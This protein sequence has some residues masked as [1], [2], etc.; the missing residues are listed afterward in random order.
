[1]AAGK[2]KGDIAM[3]T[4]CQRSFTNYL[5]LQR[6]APKTTSLPIFNPSKGLSTYYQQPADQ[7]TNDQIQEYLLHC[8]QK[9]K[10]AWAYLQCP[11]LRA[12]KILPRLPWTR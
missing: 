5:Y 4:D 12:K 6:V 8:I 9:K 2:H 1:M 3:K 7:F 11:F 10:L